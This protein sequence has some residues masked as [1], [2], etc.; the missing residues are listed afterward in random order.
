MKYHGTTSR[1]LANY[2]QSIKNGHTSRP[3]V[4]TSKGT[5]YSSGKADKLNSWFLNLYLELAEPLAIPDEDPVLAD[6][7]FMAIDSLHPLNCCQVNLDGQKV[8]GKRYLNPGTPWPA[9]G[10]DWGGGDSV[11]VVAFGGGLLHSVVGCCIQWLGGTIQDLYE[12]HCQRLSISCLGG[13]QPW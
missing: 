11:W 9:A 2:T 13:A 6:L 4:H 1:T 7:G 12:Q 8:A 3:E 5:T 10:S